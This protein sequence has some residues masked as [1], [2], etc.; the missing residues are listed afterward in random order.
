[1]TG[2]SL[3]EIDKA[4]SSKKL[5]NAEAAEPQR[6]SENEA[7]KNEAA[8]RDMFAKI[9][10]LLNGA[11]KK[12]PDNDIGFASLFSDTVVDKHRYNSTLKQWYYFNGKVWTE[13]KDDTNVKN[14]AKFF[15]LAL[16][17]YACVHEQSETYQKL[18][19][20]LSGYRKRENLV[21][22]SK[23]VHPIM[24]E[25]LDTNERLFN[26]RNGTIN[27]DTFEFYP[28]RPSDLLSKI[29][30]VEYNEKAVS[31]EWEKFIDDITEGNEELKAYIQ[32]LCGLSL[33]TDTG[34]EQFYILYG[35]STQNGKTTFAETLLHLFGDYGLNAEPETFM[36]KVKDTKNASGDIARLKGCRYLKVSEPKQ[37]MILNASIIKS[38]TGGDT[39]TARKLYAEEIQFSP[40]FKLFINTNYLPHINDDTIFASGRVKVIPFNRHFKES[41]QDKGLKNRLQSKWNMSGILNWC[42]EGLKKLRDE[43]LNE[44]QIVIEATENYRCNYDKIKSFFDE[45]MV[46]CKGKNTKCKDVY[47][48][49]KD[50]CVNNGYPSEKLC[51][52]KDLLHK[53][54]VQIEDGN[55]DGKTVHNCVKDYI[56]AD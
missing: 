33:T 48:Q 16:S 8:I 24:L 42:L 20:A 49:Y 38:L 27:L 25:D 28:H 29:S 53:L 37:G 4:L 31:I 12:Y 46:R 6:S 17:Q 55:I 35:K 30:N 10:T 2:I 39:Q 11:I 5:S 43:G 45:C 23:T 21:K 44:P 3:A 15:C 13:D 34:F 40:Q 51:K 9:G 22:D 32:K 1:M 18:V 52:F 19:T 41:E 14:A 54:N 7:A 47:E 50:W 26:C 56:I 36:E